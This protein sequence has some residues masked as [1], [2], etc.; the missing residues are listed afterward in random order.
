MDLSG[1][2]EQWA[3]AEVKRC[4]AD[5][6]EV[7]RAAAGAIPVVFSPVP[8]PEDGVDS[9]VLGL[10]VG[11]CVHQAGASEEPH[12][13][14]IHLYLDNIWD[15]AEGSPAVFI[16]EVRLTYLHELGHYFGWDEQDLED[17]GLS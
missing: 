2:R 15:Y 12:L 7:L 1:Y 5:L 14:R 3:E 8:S 9:S 13:T 16:E 10:F 11:E 17:R 6:P 4:L